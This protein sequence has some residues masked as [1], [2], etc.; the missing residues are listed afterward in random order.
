MARFILREPIAGAPP[1]A[2]YTVWPRGTSVAD[3]AENALPGDVIW[4]DI[5]ACPSPVNMAPL[6]AT[7]QARMHGSQ[8]ITL[9]DLA[10]GRA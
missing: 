9:A 3:S 4:P 1:L 6:D 5:C 2:A 10:A 7:G 8:I